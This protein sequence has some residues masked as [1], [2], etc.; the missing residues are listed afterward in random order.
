MAFIIKK[1]S[2]KFLQSIVKLYTILINAQNNEYAK[3]PTNHSPLLRNGGNTPVNQNQ[4]IWKSCPIAYFLL[5][6]Q[7]RNMLIHGS[8]K[9]ETNQSP[10]LLLALLTFKLS[11]YVLRSKN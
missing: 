10:L 9:K 1:F 11:Y 2:K 8:V 6:K 4:T 7:T 5:L 3:H